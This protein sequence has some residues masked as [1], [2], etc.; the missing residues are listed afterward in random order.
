MIT[1]ASNF[2]PHTFTYGETKWRLTKIIFNFVK[3]A[4]INWRT[5]GLFS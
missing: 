1:C 5:L 3:Y 4:V 2:K